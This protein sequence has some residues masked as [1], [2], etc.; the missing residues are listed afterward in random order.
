MVDDAEINIAYGISS[1]IARAAVELARAEGIRVGL[2]RLISLYPFP[3][4]RLRQL[5]GKAYGY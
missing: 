3:M 4:K 1:R 5:A 2:L